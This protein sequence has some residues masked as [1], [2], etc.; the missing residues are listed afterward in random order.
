M[1]Q[2]ISELDLWDLVDPLIDIDGA[3]IND[4]ARHGE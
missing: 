1:Q 3:F 2:R 4:V